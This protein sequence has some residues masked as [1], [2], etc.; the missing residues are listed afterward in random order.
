[1]TVEGLLLIVLFLALLAFPLVPGIR[2]L[3]RP[4]DDRPLEIDVDATLDPRQP[5]RSFREGL[6]SFRARAG[7]EVPFR[8]TV[9]LERPSGEAYEI[10]GDLLVAPDEHGPALMIALGKADVGERARLG[11]LYVQGDGRLAAGVRV[12]AVATDGDLRLGPACV[13]EQWLDVEGTADVGARCD[14]GRQ[15]SAAG[16]LHLGGGCSFRRLWGHPVSTET[17]GSA[18]ERMDTATPDEPGTKLDDVVM[19]TGR[20]LSVPRGLTLDRDLVVHGDV[21][22]SAG[23]HVRGSVKAYGR[24][25]LATGVKVDGN[26]ICRRSIAIDGQAEIRGNVFSEGDVVIGPGTTIGAPGG[27][28]SVY[29]LGRVELAAAVQVYGWIV[30]EGAGVVSRPVAGG[31]GPPRGEDRAVARRSA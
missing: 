19:W 21:H 3:V 23:A 12:R 8:G 29:A 20:R 1:M 5:G 9:D 22:L 17:D 15:A 24:L 30:S 18:S 2:E 28:K 27:F 10:H 4:R 7:S 31:S 25:H 14:L 13:V 16:R 26:L 6:A 11:E